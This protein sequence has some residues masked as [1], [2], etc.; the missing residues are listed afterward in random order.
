[1]HTADVYSVPAT[2]TSE[3]HSSTS[4]NDL[5]Q[6]PGPSLGLVNPVLDQAGGGDVVVLVANGVRGPQRPRE[7]LIVRAEFGQHF[8]GG[9]ELLIVVADALVSRDVADGADR[10][11]TEL[12]GAL[13][14]VVR[15]GEELLGLLVEEQVVVP[16][17]RAAH[18][19]VEVLGL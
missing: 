6:E 14:D 4:T 19:P 1:M 2:S 16:E 13:G 12:A 15:H 18:V 9:D 3:R 11:G 7:L 10:G 5:E 17:M 8:V